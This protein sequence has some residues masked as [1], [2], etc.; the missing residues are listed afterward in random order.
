M[1]RCLRL[2]LLLMAWTPAIGQ[3]EGTNPTSPIGFSPGSRASQASAEAQALTVPT[4]EHARA[5]LRTLTEE[6]HVAGTP[7]DHRT[8]LFVRD[9]LRE[10]GWQADLAEY[11]VLLNY[12]RPIIRGVGPSPSIEL[13]LPEPRKLSLGEA[14][15]PADRDSASPAAF[16]AF[17]GYGVSGDVTEQ[18]VYANYGRPEDFAAL[19]R[20]GIAVKDKIVLVRYGA[21]FRGLKVRNAQ[22]RG[23]RGVLIY[24]D[25]LD[26]GFAKGDTYPSGPYRPGSAVQRGSVQF[27]SLGPGDP[28]TPDGP[29]VKG[30]KRLP[31][32]PENGFTLASSS[33]DRKFLDTSGQMAT[34]H[35][36]SIKD[37]EKATGLKRQ[38]YFASIPSLPIGYD[39]ARPIL[40]ALGGPNVPAGWQG[41][42]PLPYHV[43]PGPA[44]VHFVIDMDYQVRTVWNVIATLKGLVEPD[45]WVILGNH[46]DAWVYGAV[47]PGSGTAATLETCRALG[48]AVKRG[49]KPRRSLVYASWDA[50]E[51]GLVGSTEW[52]DEHA[53]ELS[54]KAVLMLNVDS[55]VGGRELDI[56]GVPSLR[57][58]M[59]DA[60][61]AVTDF[62][63]GRTLR[64]LWT[65]K[66]RA[67][68]AASVPLDTFDLVWEG[69][70]SG[71]PTAAS[72]T[73]SAN[74][75]V[76][77]PSRFSP[78]LNPLGSGSDYTAFVD[79]LGIPAVEAG[80]GGGYG[81]YHSIY[82]NF[83]WMEKFCD[84]EFLTHAT[85]ARLY[86]VIAMRA[87]GAEVVPLRFTPYGE[88][89]R[90]YVDDLRRMVE[91]RGKAVPEGARPSLTFTGL[92]ALVKAV[93]GF[94]AGAIA[95]DR[96]TG[97][98]VAR[99]GIEPARLSRVNDAL[100]RVER[101]FLLAEGLPGRR[102]FKHAIYA[103]GLTTGYASW[104]LPGVRQAVLENDAE[105]L[106]AQVPL[107]VAR[108]DAATKALRAAEDEARAALPLNAKEAALRARPNRSS[109][110]PDDATSAT[111]HSR[112][113]SL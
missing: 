37:W 92:P 22:K 72:A 9:K 94:Q 99:D 8:A 105:M 19:D 28:S 38:D 61:A 26:D 58:L 70:T 112:S 107:L 43:G 46:R 95:L 66:Q 84:P 47:D 24:S 20:L 41:G 35:V 62:R 25:P 108:L 68:W 36:Q 73:G 100:S 16:P 78:Q 57:D 21:L 67:A 13:V 74:P 69:A 87:A 4:P 101:A 80:F 82:D 32:D 104:P 23:A 85:A 75:A 42:L 18:V 27:L 2:Y 54:E 52:A 44:E 113:G 65:E 56:E 3:D 60:T 30:A 109:R 12:P 102:W 79:H 53:R 48:A 49:W 77:G 103:P 89:L 90:E 34:K 33:F 110:E 81:V 88:A 1:W 51:Y 111:A 29:S 6:P 64:Q 93:R 86:T 15:N 31:F 98:L 91:R 39:A 97:A 59:L 96:A 7:A 71:A 50:E 10:W 40:E 83:Y 63:T 14:P 45:R 55:A 17:H 11:E 76:P 5:W 106:A